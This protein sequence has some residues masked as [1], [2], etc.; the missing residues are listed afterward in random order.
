M[1]KNRYKLRIILGLISIL[2][3]YLIVHF[4]LF[5][6]PNDLFIIWGLAPM[7]YLVW[8]EILRRLLKPWI[9]DYPYAPHWDKTGEKITGNGYQKNRFVTSNDRVFEYLMF[10]IPFLTLIILTIIFDK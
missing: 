5:K 3:G 8:Y 4:N 1:N 9:G 7:I 2:L 6:K 10:F